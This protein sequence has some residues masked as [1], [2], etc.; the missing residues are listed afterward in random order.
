MVSRRTLLS[1]ALAYPS[2]A[3]LSAALPAY[4]QT[5]SPPAT[6]AVV[7]LH[8][9]TMATPDIL[10]IEVRDPAVQRGAFVQLDAPDSGPQDTWVQRSNPA[11]GGLLDYCHVVGINK[12]YLRF[13][14]VPASTYYNRAAGDNAANYGSI[15]GLVVTHVY[16]KSIPYDYGTWYSAATGQS[17]AVSMKHFLFLKLS[18]ALPRGAHNI[19][20]P[21]DTGLPSTSFSFDDRTTRAIALRATQVGH[22]PRDASKL[23]Y[24]AL[25]IPG[26]PEEGAVNFSASYNLSSFNVIDETGNAVYSGSINQRVGPRDL[27]P[28]PVVQKNIPYASTNIAPLPIVAITAENP[29]VVTSSGHGLA[30]GDV[31]YLRGIGGSVSKI[32]EARP[33]T[34]TVL[35]RD[36]FSIG[37]DTTGHTYSPGTYAAGFSDLIYKTWMG[38]R[39]GTYVF[40]LDYS[41]WMPERNGSYRI[42]VHGLGVSDPFVVDEAIWYRVAYNS[43]KGAYNQRN[44]LALDGR[45]GFT[46][47]V[48][49]RPGEN[50]VKIY[51]STLPSI[52]SSEWNEA[53]GNIKSSLGGTSPYLTK[54]EVVCYGG[55]MDAGD[56]DTSIYA[57]GKSAWNL[58]DIGYVHMPVKARDTKFNIPKSSSVLDRA[59]YAGTDSLPDCVHEALWCIDFYRQAQNPDGSVGSGRGY[60]PG[61]GGGYSFEPS[62]ISRAQAFIYSPDHAS[63]YVYAGCAAKLAQIFADVGFASLA[64]VWQKSA[65]SAWAWA[66][67]LYQNLPAQREYYNG[68]LKLQTNTGWDDAAFAARMAAADKLALEGRRLAACSLLRLTRNVTAYGAIAASVIGQSFQ[69]YTGCATWEYFNTPEVGALDKRHM[70]FTATISIY[71][72][73]WANAA[74]IGYTG[75]GYAGGP[76]TNLDEA[77]VFIIRA[78]ILSRNPEWLKLL[79]NGLCFIHGANQYGMCMSSG[80]GA[81]NTRCTLHND[82]SF[83]GILP[84]AGLTNYTWW[85]VSGGGLPILNFSTDSPLNFI[86]EDPTGRFQSSY[87]LQRV[88]E[89][90]RYAL[91]L[92]EQVFENP[93]IIFQMEFTTEQ[94]VV[95]QLFTALWLHGWDGNTAQN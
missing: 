19:A 36:R 23:A 82:T 63:N 86:V 50:Q 74:G 35:D 11:H 69:G 49:F 77:A 7:T 80:I 24:L 83:M 9:I 22:R 51:K 30:T 57:H 42:H 31:V 44:G 34:V 94:N 10:C 78:H 89:P 91:P 46:R 25:W 16:R 18:G 26:A 59:M 55:W 73:A 72:L 28:N 61:G 15:G 40:G 66:E 41:S 3:L 93:Y 43:A 88:M 95:P 39:C 62:F 17:N 79:Q 2:S 5:E 27:E 13:Q 53:G 52:F 37:V 68:V 81:R 84:F 65:L 45:F 58:L 75:I 6:R 60:Y 33:L 56:W 87:G 38:N 14:D 70:N 92:W 20:F 71:Q 85:P 32:T 90:Y 76:T 8:E 21:K 47:P 54:E 67:R 29:A 1:T 48:C 12:D 4:A 64:E